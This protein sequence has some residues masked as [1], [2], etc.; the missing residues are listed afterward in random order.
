MYWR[1]TKIKFSNFF[2]LP[3]N[4][5]GFSNFTSRGT[6]LG[7]LAL[8]YSPAASPVAAPSGG[9]GGYNG[10]MVGA[11]TRVASYYNCDKSN[12][13]GEGAGAT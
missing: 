3:S 9:G 12:Y 13:T 8:E 5:N 7:Y 11:G 4:V 10:A 2:L 1:I 6:R